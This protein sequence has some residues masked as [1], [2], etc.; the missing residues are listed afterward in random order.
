M[1]PRA[2]DAAQVWEAAAALGIDREQL[3]SVNTTK[4]HAL[5]GI[6]LDALADLR[7]P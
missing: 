5:Y 6:D 4:V 7:F 2:D 1:S 3:T